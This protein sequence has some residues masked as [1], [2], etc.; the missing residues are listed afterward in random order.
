MKAEPRV[1]GELPMAEI[2]T[3]EEIEA[4]FPSE[5]VLIGDPQ[6]D[7]G[8]RLLSGT[9]LFHSPNRDDVDRKLLELRPPRFGF[10]YMGTIPEDVALVL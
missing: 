2:L 5:W 3:I 8:Q 4:R 6:T 7:E 10:R 9:V 1:K